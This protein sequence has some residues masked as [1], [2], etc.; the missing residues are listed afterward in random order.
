MGGTTRAE[1]TTARTW[2]TGAAGGSEGAIA[3]RQQLWGGG[4]SEREGGTHQ[5]V[6]T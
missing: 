3:Q 1:G 2:G 5:R 4:V 6:A